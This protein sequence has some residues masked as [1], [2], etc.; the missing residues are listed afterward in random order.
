MNQGL[1]GFSGSNTGD[2]FYAREFETSGSFQIPRGTRWLQFIAIGGG[3]GGGS[4]RTGAASTAAF[5]G[6]GGSSGTWFIDMVS[7]D[8]LQM[9]AGA[10][11]RVLVGAG[12]SGGAA[13]AT[14]STNGASGSPGGNTEIYRS[15]SPFPF[16]MIEGGSGGSGGTTTTGSGGN[17]ALKYCYFYKNRQAGQS[18]VGSSTTVAVPF[19]FNFSYASNAPWCPSGAAGGGISTGNTGVAGGNQTWTAGAPT[20]LALPLQS[21]ATTTFATGSAVNSAA[22][23]QNGIQ[24]FLGFGGPLT[25]SKLGWGYGGCGGGAGVTAN[26]GN[27]GNG[28]RG[29]AGGGGGAA[30]DGFTSGAGGSGASGYCCIIA[31]R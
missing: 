28:Y 29:G 25:G 7:M 31:M 12:G 2:P 16:I 21:S 26:G 4:G 10:E 14:N 15:E 11:L 9:S 3:G 30:R 1:F 6:G 23:G 8:E 13:I 18:G 17:A 19:A 20:R 22:A 5:G 27:G 24:A